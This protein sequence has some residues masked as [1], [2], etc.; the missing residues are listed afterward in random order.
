[1]RMKR[2]YEVGLEKLQF[3]SSQVN[4]CT[5]SSDHLNSTNNHF[6]KFLE[7]H[8]LHIFL[9]IY[10]RKL[11]SFCRNLQL[12]YNTLF[13]YFTNPMLQVADMQVELE[14]LQPQLVETAAENEKM[15]TVCRTCITC[16]NFVHAPCHM[17][18]LVV[19]FFFFIFF[20]YWNCPL[21]NQVL[22]YF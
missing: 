16:L 14:E 7:V 15:L 17:V 4:N 13:T 20:L 19:V 5:C 22:N 18:E 21:W 6:R 9:C 3:A 1:M 12:T 2:R 11:S 8:V 10:W